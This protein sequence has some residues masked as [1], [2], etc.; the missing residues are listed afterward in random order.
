MTPGRSVSEMSPGHQESQLNLELGSKVS[1]NEQTKQNKK[2]TFS[3][4]SVSNVTF[5]IPLSVLLM[6]WQSEILYVCEL[7]WFAL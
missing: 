2:T 3:R 7:S 6:I 1:E 5:K 4:D